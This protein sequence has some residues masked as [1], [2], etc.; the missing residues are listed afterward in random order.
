M[1]TRVSNAVARSS[2]GF[3]K[4]LQRNATVKQQGSKT[5]F[6]DDKQTFFRM[7][8]CR[9]LVDSRRV[10]FLASILNGVGREPAWRSG[11]QVS[12]YSAFTIKRTPKMDVV[13]GSENGCG[14][15]GH[16]TWELRWTGSLDWQSSAERFAPRQSSRILNR[17]RVER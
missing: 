15:R 17:A 8:R 7:R 5:A 9:T 2:I 4:S 14:E 11:S 3:C 13:K 1:H 12:L 6:S 10:G 16:E